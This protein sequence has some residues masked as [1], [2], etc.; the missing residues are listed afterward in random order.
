MIS[1]ACTDAAA[2]PAVARFSGQ[3]PR[4]ERGAWWWVTRVNGFYVTLDSRRRL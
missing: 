3:V 1:L 2:N 4:T